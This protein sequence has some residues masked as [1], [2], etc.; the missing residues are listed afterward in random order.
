MNENS[1]TTLSETTWRRSFLGAA[2]LLPFLSVGQLVTA[3]I[4]DYAKPET[5]I[6]KMTRSAMFVNGL[7]CAVLLLI[8]LFIC[9]PIM[10]S[11]P[12]FELEL[13]QR[14]QERRE[15]RIEVLELRRP[16]VNV[17][18]MAMRFLPPLKSFE[19]GSEETTSSPSR[20]ECAICL[21]EFKNGELI[22][23]FPCDHEFHA[24]CISSWLHSGKT[25]CPKCRFCLWHLL[26]DT[27][28][29]HYS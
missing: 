19:S 13:F 1:S 7:M 4:L 6:V 20:E 27:V 9:F 2:K 25:T 18:A 8:I 24:S 21:E 14:D 12:E 28:G 23:P 10:N 26:M 11:R 15:S 5:P 22:Q 16:S 29:L 3:W 17:S